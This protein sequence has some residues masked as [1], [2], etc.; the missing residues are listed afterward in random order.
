MAIVALALLWLQLGCAEVSSVP[1]VPGPAPVEPQHADGPSAP[2]TGD[3]PTTAPLAH[4]P[5]TGGVVA[6]QPHHRDPF[7]SEGLSDGAPPHGGAER[8]Q[9]Q[10][11][12]ACQEAGGQWAGFSN[13]CGDLC[14]PKERDWICSMALTTGCDCPKGQCFDDGTSLCRPIVCRGGRRLDPDADRCVPG[15]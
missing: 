8:V 10:L 12:A 11:E 15:S 9:A 2:A 3:S 5:S 7:E 14:S 4:D 13:G 6:E 1:T